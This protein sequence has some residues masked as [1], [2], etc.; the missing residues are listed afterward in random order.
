MK[1]SCTSAWYYS[2]VMSQ[3]PTRFHIGTQKAG[4]TYLYNL[5]SS[6][7]DTSLSERTEVSFFG[8][9]FD[10]GPEWYAQEFL[11]KGTKIDI[12]PTYFRDGTVVAPRIKA[13]YE[14]P[15][16]LRFLLILRNPVDYIA[17]HFRMHHLHNYFEKRS[18]IFPKPTED[19]VLFLK[20]YPEYASRTQY[21]ALLREWLMYFT[22]GQF[23]VV[24]FED[25][26]SDTDM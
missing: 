1:S 26:V 11:D 23:L 24:L 22:R 20:R 7:P 9:H 5:L 6:H 2:V 21:H 12:S 16:E 10:E 15:E 13:F 8:R 17:S 18:A 19:I 4:S 25:F 3:F 14:K